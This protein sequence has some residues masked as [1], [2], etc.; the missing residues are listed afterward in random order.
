MIFPRGLLYAFIRRVPALPFLAKCAASNLVLQARWRLEKR[1]GRGM[2][3]SSGSPRQQ[4]TS[5]RRSPRR[6]AKI[7]LTWSSTVCTHANT[8]TRASPAIMCSCNPG[9]RIQYVWVLIYTYIYIY[10]YRKRGSNVGNVSGNVSGKFFVMPIFWYVF[11][12]C[13]MFFACDV[14]VSM[15]LNMWWLHLYSLPAVEPPH[16]NPIIF[17]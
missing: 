17:P 9:V 8:R 5:D 15:I 3:L 16:Q 7:S 12:T 14:Q 10:V 11:V 2:M 13:V 6:N 4:A 1:Y